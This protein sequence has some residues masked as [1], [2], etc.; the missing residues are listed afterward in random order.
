MTQAPSRLRGWL[1]ATALLAGLFVLAAGLI[2][3]ALGTE[4]GTRWLVGQLVRQLEGRL[5]V[6]SVEG[7]VWSGLR[8][9][10]LAW[11]AA[12][13]PFDARSVSVR[14]DW[15]SL[16]R[17]RVIVPELDIASI[18]LAPE[19]SSEPLRP[20]ASLR[21]PVSWRLD[22]LRV[23]EILIDQ[24]SGRERLGPIALAAA[25]SGGAYRL[26][27]L[28]AESHGIRLLRAA[29]ELADRA[30]YALRLEAEFATEAGAWLERAGLPRR[31]GAGVVA[32]PEPLVIR[33]TAEG[34]LEAFVAGVS[35]SLRGAE[36]SARSTIRAFTSEPMAPVEITV[37]TLDLQRFMSSAPA[38]DLSGRLTWEPSGNRLGMAWLN[39]RPGLLDE[40]ALPIESLEG[41]L[42]WAGRVLSVEAL[43][44]RLPGGPVKRDTAVA[45]G[46]SGSSGAAGAA[47]TAGAATASVS[48]AL[49]V[50]FDRT[51]LTVGGQ[52]PWIEARLDVDAVNPRAL[53]SGW[54]A[55][56]LAGRVDIDGAR[57]R[58]AL[59]QILAGETLAATADLEVLAR[60]VRIDQLRLEAPWGAVSGQGAVDL[61]V[62]YRTAARGEL[63]RID[64]AAVL[65]RLGLQA[66]EPLRGAVSGRWSFEGALKGGDIG[67]VELQLDKSR[68]AGQPLGGSF[69]GTLGE[70][71]VH[72]VR[73]DLSLG[74]NRLQ[75]Q[76]AL[77][78]GGD[79]LDVQLDLGRLELLDERARGA[80]RLQAELRG[81][82]GAP[83]LA[84]R[85]QARSLAWDGKL[86]AQEGTAS[87]DAPDARVLL[88][89]G[90][91]SDEA[92]QTASGRIRI[93][94]SSLRLGERAV[95]HLSAEVVG[96]RT[97]HRFVAELRSAGL[98]LGLGGR[99]QA[100]GAEPLAGWTAVIEHL[101]AKGPL[102][103]R[104][105][106]PAQ[107]RVD[108][109]GLRLERL[110]L[111]S[112]GGV[113]AINQ[114]SWQGGAMAIEGET[115]GVSMRPLIDW[116]ERDLPGESG[117]MRADAAAQLRALRLDSRWTLQ[118]PGWD[119]L[120]G[121]LQAALRADLPSGAGTGPV[122]GENRIELLL[123]QGRLEGQVVLAIPSLRFSRRYTAPD[124]VLDGALQFEGRVRGRLSDPAL[125]GQLRATGL[126]LFNRSLGWR[127]REGVLDARFDSREL[128]IASLRFA[129]GDGSVELRG[130]LRLPERGHAAPRGPDAL[131]VDGRML[132]EARRL[133]VPLGPGQRLLL[134]G[135]T[136]LIAQG[137]GLSWRGTLRA[138]EG[139][140]EL[141]SGGVPELPVDVRLVDS[142][143]AAPRPSA[144]RQGA[145]DRAWAPRVGADLKIELGEGLRVRGGG[146][147]ARLEGELN[148]SGTLPEQPRVR[149]L[150]KVLDGT[151]NTYGRRLAITRGFIRFAGELDNPVL[152]IIAMRRGQT[153]SAG[154]AIGGTALTPRL[155]LVSEPDVP[156]AQK[157]SWLVLGTGLDDVAAGSQALALGEAALSLFG[158]G[159]DGLISGLSQSLGIDLVSMGTSRA[160][161]RDEIG[162]ARL[163]PPGVMG[164]PQSGTSAS[165]LARQEVVTVSKRLSSRLTF[166][167]ERGLNGLWNLIRLQYDISN[168][169]S[170]RAQ[171]G[172]ENALDLLYFWW[173]D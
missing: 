85:A 96:V 123:E 60:R 107:L 141:R 12:P 72:G 158:K 4:A 13:T 10:R 172:S 68:L 100:E 25:Y 159:D 129:S 32:A 134:S 22:A 156:D 26:I 143:V 73:A 51:G 46:S 31:P 49:R 126:S 145:S 171:S 55:A 81:G 167:Y 99:G 48:G 153:V 7:S 2:G 52:W 147:D 84:L 56:T 42:H 157:L 166:S 122:L 79:R 57:V 110:S 15:T 152:D 74:G 29:G 34:S 130:L 173:F 36:L 105:L 170:L 9:G 47:G 119:E 112:E 168:R 127:M 142:R 154:V 8:L 76:G 117:D 165:G 136:E 67:R 45:S 80:I 124:W 63:A 19:P 150:V 53:S 115:S 163:G 132:L 11:S 38:T 20:P 5:L 151:F 1:A 33:A 139:L 108:A 111:G 59:G 144:G 43:S 135:Q 86:S 78:A 133:P 66:P 40:R 65:S 138:D 160:G 3:A 28:Q 75:A 101:Q 95:E 21:L 94:L 87:L 82:L 93:D 162:S 113:L 164:S 39:A 116:L 109:S 97:A 83:S 18:E 131:P 16:A 77:G 30:P 169:L 120:T 161:A 89:F 148:L 104:L 24:P 102:D 88:Q 50:E 114:A 35:S 41:R 27:S 121:R 92:A 61:S 140:I 90:H 71:R 98:R 64:P 58:L 44:A 37:K 69:M 137:G 62:P 14:V 23:G 125:V 70:Q 54:P 91:P 146:V 103:M 17:L 6:E 106:Q 155:R 118:G 128:R 149:G